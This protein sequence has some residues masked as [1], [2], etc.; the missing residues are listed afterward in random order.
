LVI[1]LPRISAIYYRFILKNLLAYLFT[2]RVA[3]CRYIP[4]NIPRYVRL[5]FRF[6]FC[7]F[8]VLRN[9]W[10]TGV[11]AAVLHVISCSICIG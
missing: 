8:L 9:F 2:F 5:G 6:V 7:L 3:M 4:A 10:A 1:W 11:A